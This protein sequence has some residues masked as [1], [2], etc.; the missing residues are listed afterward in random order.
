MNAIIKFNSADLTMSSNEIANLTDKRHSDVIRDIRTMMTALEDD[1]DLR[2]VHEAKDSRGYTSEFLLPKD[3]TLTLVAGYNVKLRKRIIDRWLELEE[4]EKTQNPVANLSRVDL[5][6][7][8]LE[9]EEKRAELESRNALVE[10]KLAEAEP[11]IKALDR[12]ATAEESLCE[13][14][15]AK[16]L[17]V[18]PSFL[19]KFF[20]ENKWKYRRIGCAYWCA[21]QDKIQAGLMEQKVITIDRSDGTQKISWQHRVTP[22]GLV[23]LAELLNKGSN[24][25][26]YQEKLAI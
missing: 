8:A 17:N 22:K 9:A 26:I 23:K 19:S 2:H 10:A 25:D 4:K 21:Y 5:L 3:L 1:A 14:D 11:K 15:A 20:V 6:K 16:A 13:T 12:I 24:D 18:K 7:L